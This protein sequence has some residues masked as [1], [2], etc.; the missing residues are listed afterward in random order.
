MF[1]YFISDKHLIYLKDLASKACKQFGAKWAVNKEVDGAIICTKDGL[2]WT[3]IYN[4]CTKWRMLVWKDASDYNGPK[5][6]S[7]KSFN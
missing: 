4:D 3:N 2:N 1:C 6:C 5:L 7:R